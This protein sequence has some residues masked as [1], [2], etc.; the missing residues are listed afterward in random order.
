VNKRRLF[1][2]VNEQ[3]RSLNHRLGIVEGSYVVLC[4]CDEPECVEGF[5]VTAH[6][7]AEIAASDRRYLVIP[8]HEH[9]ADSVVNRSKQYVI[10]ATAALPHS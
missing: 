6:L 9:P 4:E 3:I 5:E 8:G 7:H 2:E 1:R 10:V